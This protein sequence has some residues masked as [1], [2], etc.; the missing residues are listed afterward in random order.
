[1]SVVRIG[2]EA[3]EEAN[4]AARSSVLTLEG[5]KRQY[6]T[7]GGGGGGGGERR[8]RKLGS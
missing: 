8:V 5:R 3:C 6:D 4:P 2:V 1:M 7:R